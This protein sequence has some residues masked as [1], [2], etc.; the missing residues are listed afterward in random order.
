MKTEKKDIKPICPFC[1]SELDR[2]LEVKDGWFS[3]K[4]VYCCPK[5]RKILGV[6]FNLP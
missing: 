3:D 2:L 4:R 6:N 1:E 5:C